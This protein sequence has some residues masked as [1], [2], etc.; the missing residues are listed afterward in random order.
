MNWVRRA[1]RQ[2]DYGFNP[3][4]VVFEQI[5]HQVADNVGGTC[6]T[7]ID[8]PANEGGCINVPFDVHR[9]A[10]MGLCCAQLS[11][12]GVSATLVLAMNLKLVADQMRIVLDLVSETFPTRTDNL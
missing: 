4:T 7:L 5:L 9:T 8:D 1:A 6:R 11:P 2:D 3:S 12:P 10:V